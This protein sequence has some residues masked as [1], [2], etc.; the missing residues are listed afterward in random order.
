MKIYTLESQPTK[1]ST[2]DDLESNFETAKKIYDSTDKDIA[3]MNL[4][5]KS[6]QNGKYDFTLITIKFASAM[7]YAYY[8]DVALSLIV[9]KALKQGYKDIARLA[10]DKFHSRSNADTARKKIIEY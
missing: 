2:L 3:L 8:K 7:S 6:L 9:D 1:N 5:K 10:A 4:I